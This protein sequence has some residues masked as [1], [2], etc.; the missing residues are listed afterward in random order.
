MQTY[1]ATRVLL[2]R[3]LETISR[4]LNPAMARELAAMEA[5]PVAQTR[6]T[7]LAGKCDQGVLSPEEQ[8]EYETYVHAGSLL[9]ILQAKT[10]L[11]L[12]R[13]AIS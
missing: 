3:L 5:D 12:Q 9:A 7:E 8:R 10:R 2:D 1:D 4:S 13:H 11:Y 6:I